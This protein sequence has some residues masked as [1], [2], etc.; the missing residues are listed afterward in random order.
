MRQRYNIYKEGAANDL[1][2]REYAA[3]DKERK[4]KPDSKSSADDYVFIYF[5]AG[6]HWL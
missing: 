4:R 5:L 3:I 6:A 1:V 2:I